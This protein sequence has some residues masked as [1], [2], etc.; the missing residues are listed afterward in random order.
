MMKLYTYW[1]S[2]AAYRLRIAL[3]LKGIAYESV[4]V[5]LVR[6]RDGVPANRLPEYAAV[7]P[8]MRVP[9]L[10]IGGDVLIQTQAI[11]EWLEETQ[12]GQPLLPRDA[13]ARA[14]VRAVMNIICCDIHPL[15]NS[16]TLAKL[17]KDH[18]ASDDQ[19]VA[20]MTHW[21]AEGLGAVEKMITP[22]PYAFG[23]KPTL[24]DV[25]IVPV[26]Y[27]ARRFAVPL[28]AFPKVVAVDAAMQALDAVAA[29]APGAQP[30]AE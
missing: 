28:E 22:A 27:S 21:I 29:A 24:A 25:V 20:W 7:N 17:R 15:N 6:G 2:S 12:G 10:D 13:L 8:Q 19:V 14:K 18:G 16:S 11:L 26:L 1:R 30:D 3:N 5:H 4:P 9:A 23:P